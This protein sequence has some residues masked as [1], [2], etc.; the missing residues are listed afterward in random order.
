MNI[1]IFTSDQ[2]RHIYF[3][4][5]LSRITN[6]LYCFIDPKKKNKIKNKVTKNYFSKVNISE[7]KFFK[8]K[9]INNV[10]IKNF[11]SLKTNINILPKNKKIIFIVFGCGVIKG[12]LFNY[13][14]KMFKLTCWNFPFYRGKRP[15]AIL[16]RNLDKVG[17]LFYILIGR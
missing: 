13:L 4:N 2:K 16:D 9:S 11:D 8:D 6:N 5:K 15:W 1:V 7:K 14:K 10:F 17:V 12:K 3:I